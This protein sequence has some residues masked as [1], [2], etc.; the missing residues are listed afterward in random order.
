M[1][2]KWIGHSCFQIEKNGF[3][4]IVDPYED[5][6]VPGLLPVRET[7]DLVLCSHLHG[8]H[9]GRKGVQLREKRPLPFTI[10]ELKTYHDDQKGAQRGY[11]T[12]FLID[13]G[14]VKAVHLGD[15]GCE[16]D[17]EQ[18]MQLKGLDVVMIPVG[19]YYTIDAGQAA[20]LIRKIEP[21][22]VIPMHYRSEEKGF[23]FGEIGEVGTF[24]DRMGLPVAEEGSEVE[25]TPKL[26]GKTVILE[27]ANSILG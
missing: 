11:N 4:I 22:I 14:V 5:N 3:S 1:K 21:H 27:P 6:S 25:I 26:F 7:A 9:N 23:G 10:T 24:T 13:D 19:G 17:P 15:L 12:M 18:I 2:I 20:E 8:D 16:P